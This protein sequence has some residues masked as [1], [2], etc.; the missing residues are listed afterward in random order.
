MRKLRIT[1]AVQALNGHIYEK[2][3]TNEQLSYSL[4]VIITTPLR[5]SKTTL[6]NQVHIIKMVITK[7]RKKNLK[8]EQTSRASTT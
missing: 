6:G 2:P 5:P 8:L 3:L 7:P 4:K 1:Q